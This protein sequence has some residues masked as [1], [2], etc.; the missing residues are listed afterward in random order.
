[1]YDS[2]FKSDF[3]HESSSTTFHQLAR[4]RTCCNFMARWGAFEFVSEIL[5]L[6]INAVSNCLLVA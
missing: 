4:D 5:I 6:H 2:D 1:M 3:C